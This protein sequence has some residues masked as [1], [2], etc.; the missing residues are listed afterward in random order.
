MGRTRVLPNGN[1]ALPLDFQD[2]REPFYTQLTDRPLAQINAYWARLMFTGQASPPMQLPDEAAVLKTVEDN[3][4]AIAYVDS[5]T[6]NP[7]RVRILLH[8]N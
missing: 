1:F 6:V 3:K 2:L 7:K 4:G 8:L 5:K